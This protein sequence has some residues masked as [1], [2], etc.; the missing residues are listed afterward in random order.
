VPPS[1]LIPDADVRLLR[2][3]RCASGYRGV[4]LHSKDGDGNPK[5]VARVKRGRR[6]LTLPGSRSSQPQVCARFVVAWYRAAFGD[7]WRDALSSRKS[8]SPDRRAML[9]GWRVRLSEK[10]RGWILEVCTGGRWEVV[11]ACRRLVPLDRPLVFAC[12]RDAAAFVAVWP[13][14]RFGWLRGAE[15]AAKRIW[16]DPKSPDPDDRPP[17]HAPALPRVA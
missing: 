2:C 16:G 5:Y 1:L 13:Y 11:P 14:Y 4:Y 15:L 12:E 10:F 17:P 9:R 7:A 3:G 6:L 8:R